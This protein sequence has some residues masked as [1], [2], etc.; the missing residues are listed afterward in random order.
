MNLDVWFSWYKEILEEFSFDRQMDE[1]SAEMLRKLLEDRNS[2]SPE[3]ISIKSDT[4]IFG[5]GPSLKR[6]IKELK[7]VGMDYFTLICADGAVTALLE[8][9]IIPDIVVTD[10]DGK[11]E[12]IIDSN[13]NGAIMVV[14]AHGNN[15]D[16]IQRYVPVLENVLGSTQSIPLEDVY[17]FG[18][19]TDGDRCVFLAVK[20]GAKN[21]FMAGMDFGK[22]ITRYSRPNIKEEKGLADLIKEKK[23]RYAKKLVEWAAKNED[24]KIYNLSNGEK[25]CGVPD[26]KVDEISFII[27]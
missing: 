5:A 19:F 12:D 25:V 3:D 10:L 1:K 2:L 21:I 18:G 16:N 26:I 4:I 7:K 27:K 22:I 20:L 11:M 15:M 8:E 9:K 14:H 23:L 24:I 6:N 17:N 13:R